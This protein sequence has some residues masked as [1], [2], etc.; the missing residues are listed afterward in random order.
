M[1]KKS[2]YYYKTQRHGDN[3]RSLQFFWGVKEVKEVKEVK[4]NSIFASL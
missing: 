1:F 4:D 3:I 2:V